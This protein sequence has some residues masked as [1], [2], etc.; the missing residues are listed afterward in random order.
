MKSIAI[1][2]CLMLFLVAV[3]VQAQTMTDA[4]KAEIEK[5]LIEN[6]K[7]LIAAVNRLDVA[8]YVK[9]ISDSFQERVGSGNVSARSKDPFLK[10][11]GDAWSQRASQTVSPFD[12]RAFVLSPDSA[13]MLYVGGV[14][15]T[16]KNGRKGGYGNAVTYIWRK[17]S[18]GWKVVHIHESN[19]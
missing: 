16:S 5:I 13:Y 14:Q 18:G 11:V 15:I 17:E 7:E 1:A 6:H 4:Q 2:V 3:P 8:G 10:W 9:F 12:I 19:W